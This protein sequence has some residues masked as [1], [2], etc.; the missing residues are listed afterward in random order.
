MQF[1]TFSLTPE[2]QAMLPTERLAEVLNLDPSHIIPIADMPPAVMGVCN[3]RGQVLWLV[4]LAYLLGLGA[5]F[6]EDLY[7]QK[8][9]V[10]VVRSKSKVLGLAVNKV[11]HLIGC[12]ESQIQPPPTIALPQMQVLSLC[13]KGQIMNSDGKKL[14]VLDADVI[15]DV[16]GKHN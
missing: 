4:D 7:H 15:V 2:N 8:H 11:G 1:L 12:D 5:L 16:L 9:P 14:L 13:L 3:W 10:L 6:A